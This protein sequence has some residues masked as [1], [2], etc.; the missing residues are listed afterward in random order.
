MLSDYQNIQN[1]L[2]TP[3]SVMNASTMYTKIPVA[4]SGHIRNVQ[5]QGRS[6]LDDS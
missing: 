3:N 6:R 1:R 4:D 5:S 2:Q